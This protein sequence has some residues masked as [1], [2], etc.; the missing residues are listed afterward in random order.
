MGNIFSGH[1]DYSGLAVVN[2]KLVN[3]RPDFMDRTGIQVLAEARKARKMEEKTMAMENAMYR[4]EMR[5]DMGEM[6][7]PM[8]RGKKCCD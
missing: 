8:K 3:N 7:M 1:M 4:A 5:A 6:M 2:G